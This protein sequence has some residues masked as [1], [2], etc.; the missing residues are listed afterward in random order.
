MKIA[1]IGG[2]A[3]KRYF[4]ASDYDEV[5]GLNA[6]RFEWVPKWHRMFNLHIYKRLVEYK[7]PVERD[8]EWV[9]KNPAVPFHTLDQWPD[10][11]PVRIFPKAQL[12]DMPRGDYHCGSFDM[13]IAF[14]IY[15]RESCGIDISN[16]TLHGVTL[17]LGGEPI[18]ARACLE[19]WCGYAEA[20]GISINQK[21]DCD[22]FSFFHLVRSKLVYGYDDTPLYED[23]LKK[24]GPAYDFGE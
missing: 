12:W 2:N 8:I 24:R 14:A 10:K 4:R 1:I 16:V 22:L 17:S 23:R 13:M 6:I 15:L 7:W 11:L 5:W 19:Y 21:P 18:S 20:K 9:K 3:K